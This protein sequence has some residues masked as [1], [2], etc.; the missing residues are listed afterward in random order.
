MNK[1]GISAEKAKQILQWT[2]KGNV[3][4]QEALTQAVNTTAAEGGVVLKRRAT[5][6]ARILV[7]RSRQSTT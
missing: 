1:E 2:A 6:A 5:R 4:A 3:R 7:N